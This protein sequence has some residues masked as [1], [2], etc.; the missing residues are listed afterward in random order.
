MSAAVEEGGAQRSPWVPVA[1]AV[2][3]SAIAFAAIF[4]KKADP[5]HPLVKSG[6]R[7]L[8]ASVL[9]APMVARG[10]W[11]GHLAGPVW[12]TAVVAGLLYG[13]HFGAWVWSL[14]LTSVAASVTL[15]TA[16]PLLL[17]VLGLATGRDRPEGRTWVALG[18]AAIGVTI[19]GGADLATSPTALLG[20]GL[21]ALGAA[22]MAAYLLVV[23][24]L[25]ALEVWSFM[26]VACAVGAA[27]LLGTSAALGL[28]LRP[29]SDE[30][31]LY[32]VLAAIIPQL[33]GH[34]LLTWSL[35]HTTP[36][37]VGLSTLGEPVG[38]T[39]L[40]WLWLSEAVTPW[41]GLGC[42]VVLAALALALWR[43]RVAMS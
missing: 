8:F 13:V 33:V 16:T 23:R 2:G 12:R 32:L 11:R 21:A 42:L 1:L 19:I 26:G 4:F 6:L 9:L 38:S 34:V 14:D 41:V 15:V 25:G 36:T 22:A 3:V 7:L 28:E 29:A 10:W 24:R 39:A 37:V 43:P 27:V 5:T 31:L 35:R 18:L 20:D 30:A 40:G 17:A